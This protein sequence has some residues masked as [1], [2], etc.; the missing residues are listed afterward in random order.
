[1]N[2][3]LATLHAASRGNRLAVRTT[4]PTVRATSLEA[5]R[6]VK[7]TVRDD[8]RDLVAN[9]SPDL[10][11]WLRPQAAHQWMLPHLASLTPQY[12]ENVLRGALAGAHQQQWELLDLML[13]TDPEIAACTQ[14]FTESVLRKKLIVEAHHEED[15]EPTPSALERCKLVNAALKAM[16]PAPDC[17]ENN[18]RSTIRDLVAARWLGQTVLEI[19]WMTDE[20]ESGWSQPNRL[21]VAKL[22]DVIVPRATFWVHPACYAWSQTGRLGLRQLPTATNRRDVSRRDYSRAEKRGGFGGTA[23]NDLVLRNA[24]TSTVTENLTR[25]PEHKFIIA[26]HKAKSGSPLAGSILRPLAWWW[27]ATNFCGDALFDLAQ[28]FGVPFR[29]AKYAQGTDEATKEE[30]RQMMQNAGRNGWWLGPEGCDVEF[31]FGPGGT[32]QSPQ[33][34]LMDLCNQQK[35]KVILGQTMSGGSGT[36]GKGGGQAFGEV[37]EGVKENK[38]DCACQDACDVLNQ[39]LIRAILWVNYGDDTEAPELKVAEQEDEKTLVANYGA[40]VTAGVITP[41]VDD[42]KSF[43]KRLGLPPMSKELEAQW[44]KNGGLRAKPQLL[45]AVNDETTSGRAALPRRQGDG[46]EH[47]E[48]AREKREARE[49]EEAAEARAAL[50]AS[51]AAGE[52]DF[53]NHISTLLRETIAPLVKR[54]RAIAAVEDE[55]VQ[56]EM[57]EKLLR[58]EP[59]LTE[60]LRA[61]TTLAKALAPQLE[62][63]FATALQDDGKNAAPT[64]EKK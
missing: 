27:I 49:K 17:D 21:T 55:A 52:K 11:R 41:T 39:Q 34:F 4:M 62:K 40:G 16:R 7:K 64:E 10:G 45:P 43:R 23:Q 20:D 15:E 25:F 53:Q 29:K 33:A 42:E 32:S 58:D 60:A 26:Q 57:L 30:I 9:I 56:R 61:D 50:E 37:E 59:A 5:A 12:V 38:I 6:A 63:A 14:E 28:L 22:G 24:Y 48:T 2:L 18:F 51:A 36:T 54:L 47:A 13:D 3:P 1:M 8:A 31:V 46:E 44:E 35:R 19:D